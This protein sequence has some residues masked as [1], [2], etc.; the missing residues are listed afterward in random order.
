MAS[1][2]YV[3][4]DTG[5]LRR[6]GVVQA[7]N[8]GE[9]VEV[10]HQRGL[11]PTSIGE[12]L[13]QVR[14][15]RQ[16]SRRRVTSA[17][18]AALCWQLST[19]VEGG[20]PITTALEIMTE[21]TGNPQ[22]KAILYRLLTKVS[23]GRPFSDGLKEFPHVF[24]GVSVA[25]AAAGESSGNLGQS[26][27]TL[28]EH[29]ESRDKLAKKI[30]SAMTYPVFVLILILT[31][32]TAIMVFVVPRFQAIFKQ[33][34]SRL[35][36]FTRVF[37]NVHATLCHQAPYLAIGAAVAGIGLY[38]LSRTKAGHRV[39]S[40]LILKVPLLGRLACE[41]FIAT[42]CTTMATLLEAGVPVLDVFE[43]LRG[44]TNNEVIG[45]A[46]AKAKHHVTGGSSIAASMA[47]AGFFPNMVVKM[48]QVGEESGSLAP[49]LRRTSTQ[50]ERRIAATIDTLTGLLEPMMI[51][52]IGGVVLV[53]VVAL[54]LPI[55]TMSD[56]AK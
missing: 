51:V 31:I 21:D 2:M 30:K 23:E 49:V 36:L 32:I 10:L 29:F 34:G 25:I 45:Q 4:R 27:H 1:F 28:A 40:T 54:Y 56:V 48:T 7:A 43:I 16:A 19:M 18:L 17:E 14:A 5:G 15:A 46:M 47:A 20:V 38:M 41:T 50:Y 44:M 9:A 11:T 13:S 3:A 55:F 26:L 6:E 42:F 39:L 52:V 35:P 33:L 24:S 37:M 12:T 8:P 22:L 53:V